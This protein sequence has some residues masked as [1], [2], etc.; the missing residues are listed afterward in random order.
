[1][2][3]NVAAGA[4]HL[5]DPPGARPDGRVA[6]DERWV[7][8]RVRE[9]L[10][11]RRRVRHHGRH[12]R[13]AARQQ[14]VQ[15]CRRLLHRRAGHAPRGRLRRPTAGH[16]G[17]C[18][19]QWPGGE[20]APARDQPER[21]PG[22]DERQRI[23]TREHGIAARAAHAAEWCLRVAHLHGERARDPGLRRR[24]VERQGGARE[25]HAPAGIRGRAKV[26]GARQHG[27]SRTIRLTCRISHRDHRA[28]GGIRDGERTAVAGAHRT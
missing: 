14:A 1:M 12:A 13:G 26:G 8:A 6:H 24:D 5:H 19:G 23:L 28:D 9:D 10:S 18:T 3:G 15:G 7:E 21:L 22:R 20:E 16:R 11:A 4:Q 17:A 2:R 27:V 25:R